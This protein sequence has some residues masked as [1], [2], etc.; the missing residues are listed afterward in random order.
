MIVGAN[1]IAL[2][3]LICQNS[4]PDHSDKLMWDEKEIL[5]APH[6]GNK[7]KLDPLAVHSIITRNI[8]ENSHAYMYTKSN[9]NVRHVE[10]NKAKKTLG[11]LYYN[12]ERA[13]K[14]EVFTSKFQNEVNILDSHGLTMHN[15]DIIDLLWT[16]WKM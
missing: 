7:Y 15:K 5:A 6:T 3:Y 9:I 14:F 8:S 13:M 4:V 11:T 1:G 2:S 10:L 16:N 12:N